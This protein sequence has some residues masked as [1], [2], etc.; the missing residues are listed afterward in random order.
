MSRGWSTSTATREPRHN[1]AAQALCRQRIDG[2]RSAVSPGGTGRSLSSVSDGRLVR[3]DFGGGQTVAQ[4]WCIGL[5]PITG[6]PRWWQSRSTDCSA[7]VEGDPW[8]H[9]RPPTILVRV[10]CSKNLALSPKPTSAATEPNNA[11]TCSTES[12]TAPAGHGVQ[13]AQV[14]GNLVRLYDCA[15]NEVVK[16]RA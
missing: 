2:W 3:S 4:R 11:S 15:A 6:E 16:L 7:A 5:T 9:S 14:F 12:T 10:W 13:L 1:G 8:W